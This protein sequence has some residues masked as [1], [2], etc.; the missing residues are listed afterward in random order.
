MRKYDKEKDRYTV[1]C[2]FG[3]VLTDYDGRPMFSAGMSIFD[4]VMEK[5]EN[6]RIDRIQCYAAAVLLYCAKFT[7]L[8]F[9]LSDLVR[10]SCGSFTRSLLIELEIEVLTIIWEYGQYYQ[11]FLS[12]QG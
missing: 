4:L 2:W 11:L 9:K 8:K 7:G 10:M 3:D 1:H 6:T 12:P 5:C